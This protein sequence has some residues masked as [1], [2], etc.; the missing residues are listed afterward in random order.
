MGT[1][2]PSPSSKTMSTT[3]RKTPMPLPSPRGERGAAS[4][5]TAL[6]AGLVRA[7]R[8]VWDALEAHGQQ[9]A[10]QDM[11]RHA[12]LLEQLRPELARTLRQA[13]R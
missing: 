13:S 2:V 6:R 11:L 10:R 12:Q 8:A 4:F 5:T 3:I 7:G 1:S 9:R